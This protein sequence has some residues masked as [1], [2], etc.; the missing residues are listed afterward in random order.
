MNDTFCGD[1]LATQRRLR[2]RLLDRPAIRHKKA[3]DLAAHLL[4]N[5][6]DL[7][8]CWSI[9]T[10][11]LRVELKCHRVDAG[12]GQPNARDYYPGYAEAK[13][14]DYDVPSF[15][16]AMVYNF[17]PVMQTMWHDR[18]PI[19]LA[20]IKQDSRVSPYL[21]KRISGART[22][23]KI[24]GALRTGRGGYGLICAD[25]TE[26]QVPSESGLYDCFEQTVEDVISPLIAVS[27]QISQEG[28]PDQAAS[29]NAIGAETNPLIGL[30]ASEL[31]VAH[32]VAQGMS[33]KEIAR[34]RGR[35]FS[36]ID[37]QLRSIRQ[38]TGVQS[39]S[40]LV[41]LLAK[42]AH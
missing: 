10:K 23:S 3:R 37:H 32:L 27:R 36:T 21:R 41:S 22:R 12:F 8:S 39:T 40:A 42:L 31:E 24:G 11:W 2:T 30:T 18:R 7:T 9:A 13:S 5:I 29:P 33:Y 4:L 19:V 6:D 28:R 15:G 14:G 20:D 38:K 34:I 35:S 26:H 17:D 16:G 1:V 25:W